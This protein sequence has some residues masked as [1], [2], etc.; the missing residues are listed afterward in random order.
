MEMCVTQPLFFWK[1]PLLAK[2]SKNSKKW[3]KKGVSGLCRMKLLM[4]F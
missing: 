2:M 4:A 1:N 3:P